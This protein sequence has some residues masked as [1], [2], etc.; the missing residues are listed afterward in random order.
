MQAILDRVTKVDLT[1]KKK[2]KK[3]NL[4]FNKDLKKVTNYIM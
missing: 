1:E 4:N 3:T 2:K